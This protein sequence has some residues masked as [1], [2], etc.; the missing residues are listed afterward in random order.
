VAQNYKNTFLLD[1]RHEISN[2]FNLLQCLPIVMRGF[3]TKGPNW[4]M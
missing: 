3:I 4:T 2:D 1:S